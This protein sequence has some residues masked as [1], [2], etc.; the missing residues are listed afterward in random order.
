M[1]TTFQGGKLHSPSVNAHFGKFHKKPTH[2]Y[3]TG[4]TYYQNTFKM[5]KEDNNLKRKHF[6]SAIS[7]IGT[8]VGDASDIMKSRVK[9]ILG[10][11]NI[12]R[13]KVNTMNEVDL[14]MMTYQ[15]EGFEAARQN[16][17]KSPSPLARTAYLHKEQWDRHFGN[18]AAIMKNYPTTNF[19]SSIHDVLS[20]EDTKRLIP[21][22]KMLL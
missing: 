18:N 14:K 5:Q 7:E 17:R 1:N 4:T 16:M 10:D 21:G 15:Q 3:P 11:T 22:D 6:S 2:P 9:R 8:D 12:R 19:S 20:L 13:V